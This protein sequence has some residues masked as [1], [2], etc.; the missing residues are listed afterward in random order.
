MVMVKSRVYEVAKALGIESKQILAWLSENGL[1]SRSAVSS[2][3]PEQ[4]SGVYAA[5]GNHDRHESMK[6]DQET[7]RYP[8]HEVRARK[9]ES[10]LCCCIDAFPII[11]VKAPDG[12]PTNQKI[13][14]VCS[15]HQGMDIRA[16]EKKNREHTTMWHSHLRNKIA[17]L[18]VIHEDQIENLKIVIDQKNIELVERPTQILHENLDQDVVD[19][20]LSDKRIAWQQRDK[21]FGMLAQVK[22]WHRKGSDGKCWCS[23]FLTKCKTH[24][25]V[26]VNQD[27]AKWEKDQYERFDRGDPHFLPANHPALTDNRWRPDS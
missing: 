7:V 12:L 23:L 6:K 10:C 25:L 4:I 18:K 14:K 26:T 15:K 5:F 17:K 21:A 3:T 20:A 27:L 19:K 13:C 2:L 22:A 8:Q 9:M 16:L 11:D 24:S 1:P